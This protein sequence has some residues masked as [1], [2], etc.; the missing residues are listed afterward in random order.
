ME[1]KMRIHASEL[2]DDREAII[3]TTR[4]FRDIYPTY[5]DGIEITLHTEPTRIRVPEIIQ[6]MKGNQVMV[7]D[8]ILDMEIDWN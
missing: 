1:Q 6:M 3:I 8:Y 4:D 7:I 5:V 2:T